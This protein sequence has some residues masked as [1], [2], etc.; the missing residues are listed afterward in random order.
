MK[1]QALLYI[2]AMLIMAYAC[3]EKDPE[4]ENKGNGKSKTELLRGSN[5][6]I[7]SLVSSGTD[8]WNTV[9]VEACNKDNQY[10]FRSDDSL[11][12]F[13]M[14]SKCQT[15][16]PDSTVSYYKLY[17]NDSK[18]IL[19]VNLT[20]TVAINDT[21]EIVTLDES[22][23]QLNAEYSGLPATIIFKHP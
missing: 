14:S 1:K 20:S 9:L 12:L 17:D 23:L 15:S 5:W 10:K 2:S 8:I 19:N 7:N 22:T 21:A 16:D 11:V 4:D 18:I 3:K 13:D 6:K